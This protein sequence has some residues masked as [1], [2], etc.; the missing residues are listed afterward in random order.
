MIR[1]ALASLVRSAA[2]AALVRAGAVALICR[3]ER[4]ASALLELGFILARPPEGRVR[5][6]RPPR[7]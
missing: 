3:S 4:A 7:E 5:S 2:S 6:N 1:R